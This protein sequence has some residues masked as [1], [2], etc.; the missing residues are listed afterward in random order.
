MGQLHITQIER[1]LKDT[2]YPHV[3]ITDL[4]N[5]RA[6]DIE[7][8]RLSRSLAAYAVHKFTGLSPEEAARSVTDGSGDNGIDAIAVVPEGARIVVVQS[9]WST[10]GK[11]S[12]SLEDML[13]FRAGLDDLVQLKWESFNLKTSRRKD[14]IE[15]LLLLPSVMIDVV[16]AHMGVADVSSEVRSKMDEYLED[17][18]DPTET[19]IFSYLG[20]LQIHRLLVEEQQAAK[21]DL[22]A[23]EVT[24]WG[25]LEGP[26]KAIYGQVRASEIADWLTRHGTN[27]LAKNVRVVLPDSEVNNSLVATVSHNPGSFWYYNNGITVLCEQI[28]KAPA[29]GADRR[30]GIFG[31]SGI[32][33]VNGA[34]TV[35]SLHRAKLQGRSSELEQA[36]VMVR[37]ISLEDAG[38]NFAN[39]VTR[40]TN[41]QNRIG[42]RDFL[43]LDPE[44]ARLRDEFAVEGLQYV[45][46]SGETDPT[47]DKGC[48]V[49]EATVALACSDQQSALSTQ[50]KREISRLWDDIS[51]APYKQIFNASVTYLRIW[52]CVQVMRIVDS[53]LDS[54]EMKLDGRPRGIVVHGN[55]LALHLIFQQLAMT[56]IDDPKY[57]WKTELLRVKALLAATVLPLVTLVENEYPGYPASLFKNAT[58]TARLATE[59][60]NE[61]TTSRTSGAAI[62]ETLPIDL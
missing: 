42:G 6:D 16:F 36:R 38:E 11:G 50:A 23:V 54:N 39:E 51:K 58:K 29:G 49:V 52:R 37:F 26:P 60:L 59:V 21:I 10:D 17:L 20:Q 24:D 45:Y 57:D 18:N 32:S 12:A 1:R 35:G 46:R 61:L 27:L 62:A 55:R 56:K 8:A 7:R 34:Q 14:E 53:E 19:A 2:V 15:P 22:A 5:Y 43:S 40:A 30:S 33:V 13:K 28:V 44:Q 48:S 41:T 25:Q 9:K 3:D 47:P 31:F 4:L